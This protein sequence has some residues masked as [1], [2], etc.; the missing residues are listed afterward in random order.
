MSKRG[1]I[2]RYTL[3]IKKLKVKPYSTFKELSSYIQHELEY[4]RK[5]DE[6]L[7]VGFSTRTFQRDIREIRNIFKINIEYS[8]SQRGY[9]IAENV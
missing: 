7:I 6:E 1:Y 9:F 2:S 4:M 3:I 8:K 5:D